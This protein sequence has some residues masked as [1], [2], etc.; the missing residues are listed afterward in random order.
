MRDKKNNRWGF[1]RLFGFLILVLMIVSV[2]TYVSAETFDGSEQKRVIVK[3]DERAMALGSKSQS[4]GVGT[5]AISVAYNIIMEGGEIK[6]TLGNM[7]AIVAE[8][9]KD[10]I[11]K[12]EAM[13]EVEFVEEDVLTKKLEQITPWNTEKVNAL[14][15]H[16]NNVTGMGIRFAIL[17]TGINYNHHDL[18]NNY[19]GGVDFVNYDNDPMDDDGHGTMVAGIIAAED[20]DFGIVGVA[21]NVELISVKVLNNRGEGYVSDVVKGINWAIDNHVNIILLSLGSD[22]YSE[23]LRESVEKAY[24]SNILVIAAAGNNPSIIYYPAAYDSVIAVSAIDK[25]LQIADFSSRGTYIDFAAP[26]VSILSTELGGGETISSGTSMAAPHVAGVA[27]LYWSENPEL[28]NE[29]IWDIMRSKSIDLGNLGID[30][31]YGAGL[32]FYGNME[33]NQPIEEPEINASQNNTNITTDPTEVPKFID[34]NVELVGISNIQIIEFEMDDK[35]YEI[36]LLTFETKRILEENI[37]NNVEEEDFKKI[38]SYRGKKLYLSGDICEWTSNNTFIHIQGLTYQDLLSKGVLDKYLGEYPSD[39]ELITYTVE[40]QNYRV[41]YLFDEFY[42]LE[43]ICETCGNGLFDKCDNYECFA[44]NSECYY[45]QDVSI[46]VEYMNCND[47]CAGYGCCHDGGLLSEGNND[48]CK[49]QYQRYDGC[50]HG[51]K[52]CDSNSECS[53]GLDCTGLLLDINESYQDG[54]CYDYELWNGFQCVDTRL[55][56]GESDCGG[57]LLTRPDDT[58]CKPGLVCDGDGDFTGHSNGCCYIYENWNIETLKCEKAFTGQVYEVS[59]NQDGS[60]NEGLS[61]NKVLFRINY[62][63]M[64]KEKEVYLDSKGEFSIN[65][66]H[67][68]DGW[69]NWDCLLLCPDREVKPYLIDSQGEILAEWTSDFTADL[70]YRQ[71]KRNVQQTVRIHTDMEY[72][73]NTE[74]YVSSLSNLAGVEN[75]RKVEYSSLVI[76]EELPKERKIISAIFNGTLRI[77]KDGE[78]TLGIILSGGAKIML[79]GTILISDWHDNPDVVERNTTVSLTEGEYYIQIEYYA[80][81]DQKPPIMIWT[82]PLYEKQAIPESMISKQSLFFNFYNLVN[83][84]IELQEQA[85][86]LSIYTDAQPNY[87]VSFLRNPETRFPSAQPII[88]VHGLHG[89]AG[90]WEGDNFNQKLAGNGYDI[91]EFYYPGDQSNFFNSALLADAIQFILYSYPGKKVD[92]VSHSNGGQVTLGYI[93]KIGKTPTGISIPY[94]YNVG[95]LVQIAPPNYGSHLAN[96][97]IKGET[98]PLLY[99]YGTGGSPKEPTYENIA[100]GSNFTWQMISKPLE[101]SVDYLVIM[102]NNQHGLDGWLSPIYRYIFEAD[103][104]DIYVSVAG[105]SLL[106]KGVPLIIMNED[107]GQEVGTNLPG[108]EELM[109]LSDLIFGTQY[110]NVSDTINIITKFLNNQSTAQIKSEL[111]PNKGELYID[112]KDSDAD[113]IPFTEGAVLIKFDDLSPRN[114]S[115]FNSDGDTKFN[116][117]LN[118]ETGIWYHFNDGDFDLFNCVIDTVSNSD[119]SMSDFIPCAA[120]GIFAAYGIPVEPLIQA[121]IFNVVSKF[122]GELTD[123]EFNICYNS[124]PI[125]FGLTIP[126]GTYSLYVDS[127]FTGINVKIQPAQTMMYYLSSD[128]QLIHT[129]PLTDSK[130]INFAGTEYN[131]TFSGMN[132]LLNTCNIRINGGIPDPN[133]DYFTGL[134]TGD[135][136]KSEKIPLTIKAQLCDTNERIIQF[137]L[138]QTFCIHEADT[139][140]DGWIDTGELLIYITYWKIGDHLMNDFLSA[141]SIWRQNY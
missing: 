104:S 9:P 84:T 137:S 55:E 34:E 62:G 115:L 102:G 46:Y 100:V 118:S 86:K 107:H 40:P 76:Q 42:T 28:D 53:A 94:K 85:E 47:F 70:A 119:L 135:I 48:Y 23:I 10:K 54:C 124:Q 36:Y 110:L 121:C 89:K 56:H 138:S 44:L 38:V 59:T 15:A 65:P 37:Y 75:A 61:N 14:M 27:A 112:P 96:R 132:T 16:T 64:Y 51:Q 24:A 39:F 136:K 82:T 57:G 25:N 18:D 35:Q 19:Y 1:V 120:A 129:V 74:E 97:I 117:V 130:S 101:A 7:D 140:C 126:K 13:A 6:D 77:E 43:N 113:T 8:I 2:S 30:R 133:G 63:G 17:D 5:A 111:E 114:V 52:D 109:R 116:L 128:F 29:G 103:D 91:W 125:D 32:V 105:A 31:E 93:Q 78:Y 58:K 69:W 12:L 72:W 81:Q 108:I 122:G 67:H 131:V 3:L 45:C 50:E 83:G 26:G 41:T 134:K 22:T 80:Y 66:E 21:P 92:L 71:G 87:Q 90:A 123:N 106:D 141:I 11:G 20:N 98:L 49:Y 139:N 4:R 99:V 127:V 33:D 79:N 68:V 60:F 88:L 73:R 95:K